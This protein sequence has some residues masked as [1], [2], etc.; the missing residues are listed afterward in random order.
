VP[1]YDSQKQPVE[2][3]IDPDHYVSLT[4]ADFLRGEDT[5]IEFARKLLAK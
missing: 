3:G 2:H 1:T 5:I 4:D